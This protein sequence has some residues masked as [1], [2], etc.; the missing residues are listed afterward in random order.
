M[1]ELNIAII[2]LTVIFICVGIIALVLAAIAYQSSL[3]S[4]SSSESSSSSSASSSSSSSVIIG[5][6]GNVNALIG[7]YG[8]ITPLP[9]TGLRLVTKSMTGTNP[10]SFYNGGGLGNKTFLSIDYPGPISSFRTISFSARSAYTTTI[11]FYLNIL[12]KIDFTLDTWT[13]ND[14]ILVIENPIVDLNMTTEFQTFTFNFD[15][16]IWV[17]VGGKGGLPPFL[18]PTVGASLTTMDNYANAIFFNGVCLDNGFLKA[19][20]HAGAINFVLGDSVN[21]TY[22]NL[23][24]EW[25]Q[26]DN[27]LYDFRQ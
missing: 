19:E 22:M 10:L 25:V 20:T 9:K 13:N 16:D 17:S 24:I 11:N 5:P 8:S 1:K 18:P 3:D 15:S 23:D 7:G 12:A 6:S 4:S 27:V 21:T 2:T 26:I 14:V